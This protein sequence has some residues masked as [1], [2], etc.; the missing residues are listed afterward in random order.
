MK[1]YVSIAILFFLIQNII[2]K[3]G[4]LENY[5]AEGLDNN[6]ALKQKEFSL[7]KSILELRE[8]R[9][10]FLP[11]IS[12]EGRYSRAGGGR[13]IE[14]P[15]GDL[16]NPVYNAINATRLE[17]GQQPF[18][19]P[20][21]ENEIIPFLREE[22]HETKIRATQM[23]FQPALY[24]NQKIKSDLKSIHEYDVNIYKRQLIAEIKI[25]YLY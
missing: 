18:N 8:A 14:F 9:G 20:V 25:A 13:T 23:V 19:F 24:Y 4:L 10:K 11:S 12:I 6:L 3:D 1:K 2:A 15:V 21:L 17:S 22:E 5:I 16:M 7:K